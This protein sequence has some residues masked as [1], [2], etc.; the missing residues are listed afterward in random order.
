[1]EN[2][3]RSGI[4]PI[5]RIRG[6]YVGLTSPL[7]VSSVGKIRP[8]PIKCFYERGV[9]G[10]CMLTEMPWKLYSADV[11]FPF[12]FYADGSEVGTVK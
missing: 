9:L 10:M 8:S 6:G 2:N 11:I 12:Q 4:V 7:V 3:D 5:R 1:M